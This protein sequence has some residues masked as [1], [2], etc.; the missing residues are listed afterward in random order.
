MKKCYQLFIVLIGSIGIVLEFVGYEYLS[1]PGTQF[2]SFT[3]FKYF[4]IQSNILVVVYFFVLNRGLVSHKSFIN[5]LSAVTLSIMITGTMYFFFLD[6]I[7]DPF[8]I[9]LVSTTILHYIIPILVLGYFVWNIKTLQTGYSDILIWMIYPFCYLV[10]VWVY[11]FLTNDF[12]Y[13]FFDKNNI[14]VSGMFVTSFTLFIAY[15]VLSFAIVKIVSQKNK[16]D[17]KING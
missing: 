4:T 7:H 8:G 5:Y 3:L 10:F 16:Q 12:I 17:L 9:Q 6:S 13:P 14:G 15:F 1:T 2:D 11:G